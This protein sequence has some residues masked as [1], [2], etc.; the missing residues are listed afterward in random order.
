HRVRNA[1]LDSADVTFVNPVD[2]TYYFDHAYVDAPVERMVHAL[3][4]IVVAAAAEASQPLPAAVAGIAVE[5]SVGDEHRA[6]AKQLLGKN[7]ALILLG[8]IAQRHP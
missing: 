2:Y 3:G 7:R 5:I 8:H 4:A 6:A 1:A